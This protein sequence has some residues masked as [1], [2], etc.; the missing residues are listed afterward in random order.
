VANCGEAREYVPKKDVELIMLAM[1][2]GERNDIF[3]IRI[4]YKF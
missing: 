1:F 2:V 3:A 4:S